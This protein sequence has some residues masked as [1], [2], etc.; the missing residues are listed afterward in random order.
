MNVMIPSHFAVVS[1]KVPVACFFELEDAVIFA[2]TSRRD[3]GRH[4]ET[5]TFYR[6][7]E[8]RRWPNVPI[9]VA[10][11]CEQNLNWEDPRN[12]FQY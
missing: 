8:F 7:F 5:P 4:R 12:L 3:M 11:S 10:S 1:D 2:N 9:K 6:V